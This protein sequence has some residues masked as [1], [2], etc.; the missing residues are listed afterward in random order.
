M[1]ESEN[2]IKVVIIDDQQIIIDGLI[3]IINRIDGLQVVGQTVDAHQSLSLIS[4]TQPHVVLMDYSFPD[5]DTDG[6]EIATQ[7]VKEYP[8]LNILML[9]SYDE[10]ALIKDALNKGVKGFLLKT[11]NADDLVHAIKQVAAGK[12]SFGPNVNRIF[13][14]F[15]ENN[16]TTDSTSNNTLS[17]VQNSSPNTDHPLTKRE[18]EIAQL[19]STGR[20][21]REIAEELFISSNTVDTH[22]KN[23]FGKLGLRNSVE[24]TNYLGSKNLLPP[25]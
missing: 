1:S 14:E 7:L 6:V 9:T 5:I 11:I 3:S 16:T 19:L 10:F 22:L 24:L 8:K 12:Y 15:L 4:R 23:T 2:T 18:L 20:T 25:A 17:T 13:A 21:R